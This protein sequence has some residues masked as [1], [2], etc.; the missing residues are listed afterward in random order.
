MSTTA[1]DHQRIDERNLAISRLIAE[2]IAVDPS[3]VILAQERLHRREFKS[4]ATLEWI[5]ILAGR[6]DDIVAFLNS[7]T[8]KTVQLCQSTPFLD[9]VTE[10]ERR[11]INE[12]YGIRARYPGSERNFGAT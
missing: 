3:L 2:K 9:A 5:E 11:T 4:D 6:L 1:S 8:E 12:S 7:R 10:A